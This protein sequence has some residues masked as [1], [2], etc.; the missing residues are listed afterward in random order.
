M[1]TNK[2]H[3]A[4]LMA[5][6]AVFT[7]LAAACSSDDS[8]DSS[9]GG[10]DAGGSDVSGEVNISGSSTVEP[11]SVAVAE[12]FA[13]VNPDIAVNVDGPGTSDGFELFCAGETDINDASRPVK[14]EEI[15]SCA[16][17]GIEFIEL[18]V[19]FDGITVMTNP[20]NDGVECL[21]LEDL[22]ALSGPESQGFEN[23]NSAQDLAAEL[24][25]DTE[26]PDAPFDMT[27]PGEESGTYGAYIE[28][29][30][31]PVAEVR[32]EEGA[33]S[34]DDVETLRPDYTTQAND[35][36]IIQAM[37]GSDSSFGFVGF[38]FAEEAGD[39]VKEIEIS[40]E[41]GTCV[42]PTTDTIADGTYPLSRS[43]F[44]YVNKA[45]LEDNPATEAYVDYYLS[46]GLS[47]V[48]D[49]GYIDLPQDRVDATT[50]VWDAKTTGNTITGG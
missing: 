42:S 23:W 18:E 41:D 48:S 35:N 2:S 1:R 5:V 49:V 37:Q 27:A 15:Q 36:A 19:A 29:G 46:E 40:G 34:E 24:G 39:T 50:A 22:Y 21:S 7:L 44:I 47:L 12:S 28:L 31:A 16:D 10:G 30:T 8:S 43:L 25:S 4:W 9:S 11:I 38:A 32:A 26:F 17:A 45:A 33:V 3:L 6:L 13:D 14:E 20:A